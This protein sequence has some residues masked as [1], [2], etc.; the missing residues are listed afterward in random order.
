MGWP[1]ERV[2]EVLDWEQV[3]K[4]GG[5]TAVDIFRR[6]RKCFPGRDLDMD[7]ETGRAAVGRV[8]RGLML[9]LGRPGLG[10]LGSP[11]GL[12][13]WAAGPGTA[14]HR[15]PGQHPRAAPGATRKA[16]G[17]DRPRQRSL[18]LI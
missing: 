18:H 3:P 5:S 16:S 7:G 14:W 6:L 2:R 17:S 11:P 13:A 1:E 4:G 9:G 15:R 12:T 8:W 10:G